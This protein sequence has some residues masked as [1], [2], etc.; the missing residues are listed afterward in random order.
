MVMVEHGTHRDDEWRN[1]E[2]FKKLNDENKFTMKYFQRDTQP[3]NN[4]S[5]VFECRTIRRV[6][7]ST[8][9]PAETS[10]SSMKNNDLVGFPTFSYIKVK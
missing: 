7:L 10:N 9:K 1:E 5:L 6:P 8:N 3:R 2:T 4:A